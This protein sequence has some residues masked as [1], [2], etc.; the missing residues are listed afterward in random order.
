[1]RRV[2]LWAFVISSLL[3]V[4]MILREGL[5]DIYKQATDVLLVIMITDG[6]IDWILNDGRKEDEHD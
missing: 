5:G 3:I 2:A 1:M 4:N 6:F